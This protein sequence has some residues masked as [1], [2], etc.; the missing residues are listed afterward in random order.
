MW[1][2]SKNVYLQNFGL[3]LCRSSL[4]VHFEEQISYFNSARYFEANIS[5]GGEGSVG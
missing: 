3:K 5:C 2:S 4:F 1:F